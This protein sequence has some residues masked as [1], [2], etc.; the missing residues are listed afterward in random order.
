[1]RR[2]DSDPRLQRLNHFNHTQKS[3]AAEWFN[4]TPLASTEPTTPH[5]IVTADRATCPRFART[6]NRN[7][8][9]QSKMVEVPAVRGIC[10]QL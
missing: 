9:G 10:D 3:W 4:P 1:M 6:M 2:F 5:T 8:R 7:Y